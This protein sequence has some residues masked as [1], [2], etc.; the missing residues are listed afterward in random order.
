MKKRSLLWLIAII[1]LLI[2]TSCEHRS[3]EKVEEQ[4]K[5]EQTIFADKNNTSNAPQKK[6]IK[7]YVL[8][9]ADIAQFPEVPDWHPEEMEE[10][11][12]CGY[13]IPQFLIKAYEKSGL[14]GEAMAIC[15]PNGKNIAK[16]CMDGEGQYFFLGTF[17]D[18]GYAMLLKNENDSITI[19]QQSRLCRKLIGYSY[20]NNGDW[21]LKAI[22][23]DYQDEAE[24]KLIDY[25][26]DFSIIY[27][28]DTNEM[29]CI[30]FGEEIGPRTKID[31]NLLQPGSFSY[32]YKDG[33]MRYNDGFNK[34][35]IGFINEGRL[36]Y[37]IILKN[38]EEVSFHLYVAD[39]LDENVKE[40]G[41]TEI[42]NINYGIYEG[43]VYVIQNVS[44][45]QSTL[46]GNR[47]IVEDTEI[48][49]QV[50]EVEIPPDM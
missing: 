20:Y 38:G 37:P 43:K 16:L 15:L 18:A 21:N 12:E 48:H 24:G 19:L 10:Q 23:M 7:S 9:E 28:P 6:V 2:L 34:L 26:D 32:E 4:P 33:V 27:Y 49:L 31:S 41:K 8:S 5:Q 35:A 50:Q 47:L 46:V 13:M 29:V 3:E 39:V 30:R 40:A 1:S 25:A 14:N 42:D 17:A 44:E 36:I 22:H 11:M 45:R